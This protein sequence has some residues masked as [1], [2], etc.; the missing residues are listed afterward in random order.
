MLRNEKVKDQ[1]AWLIQRADGNVIDQAKWFAG[2]PKP[3][4]PKRALFFDNKLGSTKNNLKRLGLAMY[5]YHDTHGHFPPAVVLG[6]DGKT[7]HSWRVELLPFVDQNALYAE[8]R[9]NEPWDSAAN[10]KVLAQM[11]NVFRS[12]FDDPKSIKSGY[13]ALVGPGTVFGE[14]AGVK[15]SQITDGTSNTIMFVEAKRDIPWTKP[16]DIAFDAERQLPSLGGFL[17]GMFAVGMADGSVGTLEVD[18]PKDKLKWLILR[19]DGH[20]IE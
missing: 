6:P 17:D 13:Y 12:P 7:P 20:P 16:E 10:L 3:V 5:N 1:L 4:A 15:V 14:P 19:N 18:L 9:M 8:Y 2:T 11:P